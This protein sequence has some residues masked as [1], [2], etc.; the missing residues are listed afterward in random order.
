MEMQLEEQQT[1]DSRNKKFQ[2]KAQ[3]IAS[4]Q[5]HKSFNFL[6]QQKAAQRASLKQQHDDEEEW[7]QAA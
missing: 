7:T 3:H 5:A 6:Q 1:F 2:A 4:N